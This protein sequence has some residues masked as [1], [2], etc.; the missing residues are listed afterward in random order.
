MKP[1]TP[2]APL[3]SA[4]FSPMTKRLLMLLACTQSTAV[5]ASSVTRRSFAL[6]GPEMR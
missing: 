5:T 3:A 6:S 2:G 1:T 4:A